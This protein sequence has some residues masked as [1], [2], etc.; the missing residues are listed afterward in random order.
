LPDGNVGYAGE[1]AD[2]VRDFN[3]YAHGDDLALQNF[4]SAGYHRT[5]PNFTAA[6]ET[7]SGR[8]T[9]IVGRPLDSSAV[10]G[11]VARDSNFGTGT[12]SQDNTDMS[13][14]IRQLNTPE[15]VIDHYD[16]QTEEGTALFNDDRQAHAEMSEG[17]APSQS[18]GGLTGMANATA[19]A[20]R[21]RERRQRGVAGLLPHQNGGQQITESALEDGST[22]QVT[23][24]NLTND[25]FFVLSHIDDG[26]K[27]LADLTM[28][29][30]G[31]IKDLNIYT[32]ALRSRLSGDSKMTAFD[33][34][35]QHA[36][37]IAARL[38]LPVPTL[39]NHLAHYDRLIKFGDGAD[40]A[41]NPAARSAAATPTINDVLSAPD[42]PQTLMTNSI[43]GVSA[44]SP[45]MDRRGNYKQ[46]SE[47]SFDNDT[48]ALRARVD[49]S[50]S[51][52]A[53]NG[54]F[55]PLSGHHVLSVEARRAHAILQEH[56]EALNTEDL[57]SMFIT[58]SGN[59]PSGS[60]FRN[61]ND[62]NKARD[63]W[64]SDSDT[65][66]G[67]SLNG[68]HILSLEGQQDY[69][70]RQSALTGI[71]TDLP[72][73]FDYALVQPGDRYSTRITHPRQSIFTSAED[74]SKALHDYDEGTI[75]NGGFASNGHHILSKQGREKYD[76][77][78]ADG[79][80]FTK[81]TGDHP[82]RSEFATDEDFAK[83]THDWQYNQKDHGGFTPDG[84]H[85]LSVRGQRALEVRAAARALPMDLANA[86]GFAIDQWHKA[87]RFG[88][89]PEEG[90][91]DKEGKYYGPSGLRNHIDAYG[92]DALND[93]DPKMVN[94][95][96]LMHAFNSAQISWKDVE[97]KKDWF[98]ST[99]DPD[100]MNRADDYVETAK[101]IEVRNLIQMGIPTDQA[102]PERTK[103]AL[104][105]LFTHK[106]QRKDFHNDPTLYDNLIENTA[107]VPALAATLRKRKATDEIISNAIMDSMTP[108]G[109]DWESVRNAIG[110]SE[111][112]SD[113]QEDPQA[114]NF[115]DYYEKQEAQRRVLNDLPI[116]HT[117]TAQAAAEYY[118]G[119]LN[120]IG[121]TDYE[122][123]PRIFGDVGAWNLAKNFSEKFLSNFPDV[124]DDF[125]PLVDDEQK[126]QSEKFGQKDPFARKTYSA[127]TDEALFSKL[128]EQNYH[129]RI[130]TH[131]GT[132]N[133][134]YRGNDYAIAAYHNDDPDKIVAYLSYNPANNLP[135][136][137][138][139]F[140]LV[141]T[142]GSMWADESV[143]NSPVALELYNRAQAHTRFV[144][145]E[146]DAFLGG[147]TTTTEYSRRLIQNIARERGDK[148][149]IV[150]YT[151]RYPE[152]GGHRDVISNYGGDPGT[153][154]HG[155][156]EGCQKCGGAGK[157]GMTEYD[158][159]EQ[160][161]GALTAEQF[162]IAA[163]LLA[164]G[165]RNNSGGIE[166]PKKS[167]DW[168]QGTG[169]DPFS[170]DFASASPT[171]ENN[172]RRMSDKAIPVDKLFHNPD[173]TL[174][175]VP[176]HMLLSQEELKAKAEDHRQ[177]LANYHKNNSGE[178]IPGYRADDPMGLAAL[179]EE[180]LLNEAKRLKQEPPKVS[181]MSLD[182]LADAV[183]KAKA[184]KAESEATRIDRLIR[185][186]MSSEGG[187][188][189]RLLKAHPTLPNPVH[190]NQSAFSL[191]SYDLERA[192]SDMQNNSTDF[193]GF[194][195]VT[196]HHVKSDK[197]RSAQR[198]REG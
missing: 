197:A 160:S 64:H 154:E 124:Q 20:Q 43:V 196:G 116:T 92:I 166:R 83:A 30:D 93:F 133:S 164:Q 11:D 109:A 198:M 103:T 88:R 117:S 87:L 123:K 48:D 144:R 86:N 132:G 71:N 22:L 193:G 185:E 102:T 3:A 162:R 192:R 194:D 84:H 21:I 24:T 46:P 31:T 173:P 90:G 108:E 98:E 6:R 106:Y 145:G 143:R 40:A 149:G 175:P 34:L 190:P 121:G 180:F 110:D 176:P 36:S 96:S 99:G 169:V 91:F 174:H 127:S 142:I 47:S 170:S 159:A 155:Y 126:V 9:P 161:N 82:I 81:P 165:N 137:A 129:Y 186:Q 100:I 101:T 38:G 7:T 179:D 150:Y 60:T 17:R 25:H 189:W 68:H 95:S 45:I 19:W 140:K 183:A 188:P 23:H 184:Q 182:E 37:S 75:A 141:G 29:N 146:P 51:D 134:R 65:N 178:Q 32:D 42:E 172:L 53:V 153:Y 97:A 167:C 138:S 10:G 80:R 26:I 35:G 33:L 57:N 119:Y 78:I 13:H 4:D 125:Q 55:D 15:P 63:D 66:G 114:H 61:N 191:S 139:D 94:A 72:Q 14:D 128:D 158:I 5:H 156:Y 41:G 107:S 89:S 44:R 27:N 171:Q 181:E 152:L 12:V 148:K 18:I 62:F 177:F 163:D 56:P 8:S 77:D 112:L 69:L 85:V 67:F 120:D 28:Q 118:K 58:R 104:T 130:L 39:Q 16:W 59:S 50:L 52:H 195:P 1:F 49:D 122:G 54:G 136:E 73:D 70:T 105:D 157:I 151:S 131:D 147:S 2:H 111:K 79:N 115:I 135:E 113:N 168:C 74:Y 187:V 76:T